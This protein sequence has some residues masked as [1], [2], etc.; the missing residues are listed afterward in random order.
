MYLSFGVEAPCIVKCNH[1]PNIFD[2][3]GVV[4]R[5]LPQS[6]DTGVNVV[7]QASLLTSHVTSHVYIVVR[8]SVLGCKMADV[9]QPTAS[10]L[11]TPSL[12]RCVCVRSAQVTSQ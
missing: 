10:L 9:N 12:S 5:M 8:S 11:S 4:G 6:G 7:V 1:E 3:H 2:K